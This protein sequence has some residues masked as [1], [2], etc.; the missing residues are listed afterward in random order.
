MMAK[1]ELN[2]SIFRGQIRSASGSTTKTLRHEEWHHI[3]V[4]LLTNLDEVTPYT[5]QFL[6][7]F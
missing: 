7:E 6:D 1:N 5:E 2:L 4:Y 3:M